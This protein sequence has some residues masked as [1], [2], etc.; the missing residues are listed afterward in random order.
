MRTRARTP[1]TRY[2]AGPYARVVRVARGLGWRPRLRGRRPYTL[3][4][5]LG[6]WGAAPTGGARATTGG[7]CGAS[8]ELQSAGPSGL[9]AVTSWAATIAE[10]QDAAK[11]VK[12]RIPRV[13]WRGAVDNHAPSP[14]GRYPCEREWGN[15][16]RLESLALTREHPDLFDSKCNTLC[17]PRDQVKHPKLIRITKTLVGQ[18]PDHR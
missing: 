17:A 3:R 4:R 2:R 14:S 18:K 8:G 6:P 1:C 16:A 12:E 11:A 5:S 13:F 15:Y 7:V 9:N 10:L